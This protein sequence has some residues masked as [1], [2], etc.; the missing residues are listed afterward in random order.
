M[1]SI[2]ETGTEIPTT[3]KQESMN[4]KTRNNKQKDQKGNHEYF[5]I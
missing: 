4:P 5:K 1:F 3:T 2:L